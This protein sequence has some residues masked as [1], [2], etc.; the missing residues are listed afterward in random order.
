MCVTPARLKQQKEIG[1]T[2]PCGQCVEC[3]MRRRRDWGVRCMHEA[4]LHEFNLFATLTYSEEFLPRSGSLDGP[5]RG[6]KP[7]AF[8]LFMKR[9]RKKMGPVRF[10]HS[11]EYGEKNGRPHYHALLFGLRFGDERPAGESDSGHP[12]YQSET[13]SALWPFGRADYGAVTFDS[14]QYVAGYTMQKCN[15]Q[16]RAAAIATGWEPEYGTMSRR[17]GIAAKWWAEFRSDVYRDDSVIVGGREV[18]P[19]RFYDKKEAEL[20]EVR[21]E[22]VKAR[23]IRK[24]GERFRNNPLRWQENACREVILVAKL[25]QLEEMRR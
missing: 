5:V 1:L 3:R 7:G 14:A 8:A 19:P 21:M 2:V 11:G 9:L 12:L 16:Q 15:R 4:S 23:R 17:P 24:H 10:F 25:H 6:V 20:D 18:T 13:L 22:L